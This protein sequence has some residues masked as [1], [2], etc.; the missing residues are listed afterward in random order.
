M[1]VGQCN[2]RNTYTLPCPARRSS[3]ALGDSKKRDELK[4][5]SRKITIIEC[6]QRST[7][8]VPLLQ[9]LFPR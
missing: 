2:P 3:L 4:F 9:A 5:D 1:I 8:P 7:L 6:R